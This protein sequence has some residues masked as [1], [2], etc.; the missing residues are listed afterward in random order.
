MIVGFARAGSLLFWK[1]HETLMEADPH[2]PDVLSFAA[3]GG[4]VA[5]LVALTLAAGPVSGALGSVA[6]ELAE[7]TPYIAAN[8]LTE[9]P[10]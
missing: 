10:Q 4:L 8:R 5:A 9:Q 2:E 7:R 6:T 1:S 3:V